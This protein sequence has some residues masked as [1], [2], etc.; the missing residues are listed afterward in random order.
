M[1]DRIEIAVVGAHLT[2]MPLN[3]ELTA[4]SGVLLRA[5]A[6]APLYRLHALAGGP[7]ERPGLVR[8]GEGGGAIETEVWSLAPDAFGTFVAGIP[9]PLCIGTL[10]LADGTRPKGFLCE[11]AGLDGAHDITGFGGWRAYRAERARA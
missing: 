9:A 6:T 3:H 5:V 2:G 8:V 11:T 1:N 10:V 7:P 4:R